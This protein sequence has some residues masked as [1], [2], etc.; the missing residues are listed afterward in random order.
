M[1]F[2]KTFKGGLYYMG[3]KEFIRFLFNHF[4]YRKVY[5]IGD[6]KILP[7]GNAQVIASNHQNCLVDAIAVMLSFKGPGRRP[8]FWARA[9]IF[10]VSKILEKYLRFLGLIPAFR[11]DHEGMEDVGKNSASFDES[12]HL[13]KHG[14]S[15]MIF[16]EAGHQDKRFLGHFTTGYTTMAFK[17]AEQTGFEQE[18]FILPVANH[19]TDYFGMR[20]EMCVM[21]ADPI[22]LKPYYEL[23]KEKPR[24]AMREVNQLVRKAISSMMLNIQDLDNYPAIDFL[25]NNYG[26]TFA[27]L[28]SKPYGTL[29]EKLTVEKEFVA[30]LD[31]LDEEKRQSVYGQAES[32]RQSLEDNKL[33]FKSL[34]KKVT[35]AGTILKIIGMVLLF[36]LWIFSLWPNFFNYQIPKKLTA[37]VKDKMLSSS[38]L[39]GVNA[40]ITIPLFAII[41]FVLIWCFMTIYMA[42]IYLLLMPPLALFCWYYTEWWD[43]LKQD[44]RLLKFHKKSKIATLQALRKDSEILEDR[45]WSIFKK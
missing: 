43:A 17:A 35:S 26:K 2:R 5:K 25:R 22:S 45:L 32:L 27:A 29:P 10:A 23:Y 12:Y 44:L 31:S 13:L 19:Y 30:A 34:K 21:F 1:E 24:T 8:F 4:L 38:F 16:P 20:R 39:L 40:V 18:I 14:Q 15:V 42:I 33:E 11:M 36:P 9:D 37:R 3:F 28:C 7:E 6:E 41:S